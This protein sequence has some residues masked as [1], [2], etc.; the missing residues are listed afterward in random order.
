VDQTF[1]IVGPAIEAA[2]RAPETRRDPDPGWRLYTGTYE[3]QGDE[4]KVF[5]LDG[6]LTMV[7]PDSESPWT[8]RVILEPVGPHTFR[9]NFQG[10]SYGAKGELLRFE[11][12]KAGQVRRLVTPGSYLLKKP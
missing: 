2:T 4:A 11:L 12:D 6:R 8:S 3:W 5:I 9:M 1:A 7:Q 10:P